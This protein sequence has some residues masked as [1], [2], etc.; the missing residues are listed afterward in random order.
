VVELGLNELKQDSA[1]STESGDARN[2]SNEKSLTRCELAK[3]ISPQTG[4]DSDDE[5][6][7]GFVRVCLISK[8]TR[9]Q[10]LYQ[11]ALGFA[12]HIRKLYPHRD[13]LP[14]Y[15]KEEEETAIKLLIRVGIKYIVRDEMSDDN[16]LRRLFTVPGLET[17]NG[18]NVLSWRELY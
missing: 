15:N 3:R 1:F 8:R 17:K 13:Y 7:Q 18:G 16:T 5:D 6:V 14:G 10:R 4:C 9:N 11:R 12:E 2:T